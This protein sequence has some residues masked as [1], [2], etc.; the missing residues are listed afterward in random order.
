MCVCYLC[1][2]VYIIYI[3]KW[4]TLMYTRHWQ[5]IVNLHLWSLL[6]FNFFKET[7]LLRKKK[8]K[9]Y[10]FSVNVSG[11]LSKRG[12]DW[13]FPGSPVVKNP[14]SNAGDWGSIP[15]KGSKY[16]LMLSS[17]SVLFH[18][19]F[20]Y[21]GSTLIQNEFQDQGHICTKLTG[22]ILTGI[23]LNLSNTLA[24]TAILTTLSL[25]ISNHRISWHLF[26]FQLFHQYL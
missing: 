10:S 7:T 14:P 25:W 20:G 4:I 17:N 15:G 8:K 2:C 24:S 26:F 12:I 23:V 21:L 11:I 16:G 13:D 1:V 9:R 6:R 22:G 5:I 19:Y 3:Y 18:I